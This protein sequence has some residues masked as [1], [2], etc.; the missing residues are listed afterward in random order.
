MRMTNREAY[1]WGF[2]RLKQAGIE[3]AT[4]DAWYLL[5]YV[6]GM[7]RAKYYMSLE[8][9]LQQERWERYQAYI[10]KRVINIPLQHITGKQ[11]FMGLE[12]EVNEHVLIPRQDT[13]V[14]VEEVLYYLQPGM[15]LLDMCTGSGCIG[16]SLLSRV[17]AGGVAVDISKE[18][19]TV[20]KRNAYKHQVN[21]RCMESDLFERVEGVFDIIVSNPPYIKTS[22]IEG[23]QKEVKR[24]E[25]WIALDGQEDGLYFYQR[26]ISE[27]KAYLKNKGMLFFEIGHDQGRE[28][29]TLMS[30]QGYTDIVVKRDLS[31][32]DRVVFGVYNKAEK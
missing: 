4:L 29:Q 3:E 10:A 14:L 16:I 5:E 22:V 26:I 2:G 21:M 28:V 20:A 7:S 11:E 18:A 9:E 1:E 12:F 17:K 31:G 13:E 24:Y 8:K 27:S 32:L 15:E 6:T 30:E 23:L 19:L 25:P